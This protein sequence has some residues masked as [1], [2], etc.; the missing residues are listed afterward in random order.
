MNTQELSEK[1]SEYF[2][3]IKTV[4]I[5]EFN[6]YM[7]KNVRNEIIN[8]K[9]IF[10]LR[11]ELSYKIHVHDDR[12]TFNLD[13]ERFI[14]ENDLTNERNLIDLNEE[15]KNYINYLV[16]NRDNVFN[17]IKNNLLESFILL[18]THNRKDVVTLGTA[19]IISNTLSNKYNLPNENIIHSKEE[20]AACYIKDIVGKDILLCGV[21]NRDK[22]I[23]SDTFDAYSKSI[24]YELF[25]ENIN[26]IYEKLR[27]NTN[28]VF[29]TDSLYEYEKIDYELDK[30][31]KNVKE[32]KIMDKKNKLKR[33]TS[34]KRSIVSMQS[35][36]FLYSALEQ[37]QLD[38]ALND[39]NGILNKIALNKN[40]SIDLID[41][42]YEA[43]LDVEKKINKLII[44]IWNNYLTNIKNKT[45][46]FNYLVSTK[47]LDDV[48]EAK[49]VSSDIFDEIKRIDLKF[50]Y[51]CALSD[52]AIIHASTKPFDYKKIDGKYVIDNKSES[53]LQTPQMIMQSNI[54][55]KTLNNKILLDKNKTRFV[56]V[57]CYLDDEL[58]DCPNYL[59]A[60]VLSE[61]NDLPLVI[62]NQEQY[63]NNKVS[64]R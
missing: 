30:Y 9:P 8:M 19:K 23:I 31:L 39:I 54:T 32:E 43:I 49:L 4:Y 61:D 60:C 3:Y 18:F 42:E 5:N 14:K 7:D 55:N 12:I 57:Y 16:E 38:S 51:I 25:T 64:V 37:R 28:K 2:E 35:H 52:D 53:I 62:L 63:E 22:T 26:K 41:R 29:L 15:S 50:G 48:I 13:L 56:G 33:L 17:V 36:K 58:D 27:K 47:I 40:S 24:N 34:I 6:K 59:K 46:N 10:E 1:I 45:P 44:P 11:D 21:I 20:D